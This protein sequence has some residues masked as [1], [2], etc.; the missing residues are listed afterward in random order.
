MSRRNT[1]TF[2][3]AD[4][5]T[6]LESMRESEIDGLNFA[7]SGLI[8]DAWHIPVSGG[9]QILSEQIVKTNINR[10][11]V[12]P[13]DA[14]EEVQ[15]AT[16]AQQQI[17]R[18]LA[19]MSSERDNALT[20]MEVSVLCENLVTGRITITSKQ[21][22]WQ[23][24]QGSSPFILSSL[25][26]TFVHEEDR[27]FF[28]EDYRQAC[29]GAATSFRDFRLRLANGR[30]AWIT[31]RRY[32]VYAPDGAP[33]KLT[34][35]C[36]DVTEQREG[37]QERITL[38][39]R[40]NLAT[41]AA[42]VGIFEVPGDGGPLWWSSQTYALHGCPMA[43]GQSPQA[44]FERV[45][46]PH[47]RYRVEDWLW[48]G[49][50]DA[51]LDNI[52]YSVE[53]P[54]G[55]LHWLACKGHV[56]Y[57]AEGKVLSLMG[58]VWDITD[59]RK[60]QAALEARRNAE[61]ANKGKSNFLATMSHEIR[62]PMNAVIGLGHLVLKTELSPKQH[63]YLTKMMT[64]ADG[65][66]Q[67]LNDILDLSKIEAGKLSLAATTFALRKSLHDS[68]SLMKCQ[69]GAKGVKLVTAIDPLTP[70]H[71]T[72]DFMRLRQILFNLLGNAIKFTQKGEIYLAVRPL[73][74]GD[75]GVLLEFTIR[76]TGI[77]MTGEQLGF[78]FEPFT[79]AESSTA[80]SYG[81][82]GLGLSICRQLVNLMGGTIR[83]ASIPGEGSTFT[84]TVR[85]PQGKCAE[86]P[87]Q[88][89][90]GGN[91]LLS[92]QGR[93]ILVAEDQELNQLLIREVLEQLGMIVTLAGNGEEAV[94]AATGSGVRY[95][96]VLMDLRMPVMDGYEATRRIKDLPG[97][98][99]LPIIALTADVMSEER[100]RCL[101]AGMVDH[102]AKPIDL[103]KLGQT[104]VRWLLPPSEGE[105]APHVLE[106]IPEAAATIPHLPGFNLLTA[107]HR[108]GGNG[109][110]LLSLL[111]SFVESQ[112]G[113]VAEI[114]AALAAGDSAAALHLAHRLRGISG[115]LA[116][117]DVAAAAGALEERLKNGGTAGL[118]ELLAELERRLTEACLVVAS[119][120]GF[121][122]TVVR[123][124]SVGSCP[125]KVQLPYGQEHRG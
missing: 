110:L 71:L 4:L 21:R 114:R 117:G 87:Q 113:V 119:L 98:E 100:S 34:T 109:S 79:Q 58:V 3:Q 19:E 60:I 39:K 2:D 82:T 46:T 76:D 32:L 94:L 36:I 70:E 12:L 56:Q 78:I 24:L 35:L 72:G 65:L 20:V 77:G 55:E 59:H 90:P 41:N 93:R 18:L 104:L 84:F 95:D 92:L 53:F 111:R 48:N 28:S 125:G 120:L 37:E 25:L 57:S 66:L 42:G 11:M 33:A 108:L 116:A 69:A 13:D 7:V 1:M 106:K 27:A 8:C 9:N 64:A 47:D 43:V 121:S 62:T 63:D 73:L 75:E 5:P 124:V 88:R 80:R 99:E 22:K 81:G 10:F 50:T 61:A 67:L 118:E 68:L 14:T 105:I 97:Y 83:G 112:R 40:L 49:L 122:D 17:D 91:P 85:L 45:V 6:C 96:A 89:E 86:L 30:F 44:I 123:E 16:L 115:N 103:N 74:S 101:E 15:R 29:V 23:L 54:S 26:L 102:L 38:A 31:G 51:D 52:E 107:L